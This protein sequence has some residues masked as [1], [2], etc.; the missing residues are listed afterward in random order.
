MTTLYVRDASGFREAD[1]A[2]VLARA[3]AILSQRFRAGSPALTS[4]ALTREYLRMRVAGC[5]RE[6][7]GA[8]FLD[9]RHRVIAVEDLFQGTI[10]RASV[11]PREVVRACLRHNAASLLLFHNH[12][13][14]GIAEPSQADE[15]ITKRIVE[16]LSLVDVRVLDH[17][18]IGDGIFSFAEAGL[19]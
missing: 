9:V 5:D 2:D 17:L 7:F 3:R 16:G 1:A 6:I 19:L 10:D 12:A 15:L 13:S 18:I 11:H 8:I 4:P 14:S